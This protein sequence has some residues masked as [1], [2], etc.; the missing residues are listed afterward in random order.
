MEKRKQNQLFNFLVPFVL[1]WISY[2]HRLPKL[3]STC[4]VLQEPAWFCKKIECFLNR[5]GHSE[6]LGLFRCSISIDLLSASSACCYGN[7]I[8]SS[9]LGYEQELTGILIH[10]IKTGPATTNQVISRLLQCFPYGKADVQRG[11]REIIWPQ[12]CKQEPALSEHQSSALCMGLKY[13]F[14]LHNPKMSLKQW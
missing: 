9:P 7:L 11:G 6:L 3:H 2:K 4:L 5:I 1:S 13:F 12:K 14:T 10:V 8:W